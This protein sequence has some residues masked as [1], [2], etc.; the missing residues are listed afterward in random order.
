MVAS[1]ADASYMTHVTHL[2]HQLQNQ[3]QMMKT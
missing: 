1:L 2:W 3:P